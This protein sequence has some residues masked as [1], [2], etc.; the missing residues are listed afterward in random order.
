MHPPSIILLS[1]VKKLSHL[2]Q[3]QN[4]QRSNTGLK[5]KRLNEGF[6]SYKHTD[7]S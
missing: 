2:N 1:P 3:E 4:M 5:L 6:V 7:G